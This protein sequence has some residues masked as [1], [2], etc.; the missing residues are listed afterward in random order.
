M[1]PSK[2]CFLMSLCIFKWTLCLKLCFFVCMFTSGKL[3]LFFNIFLDLVPAVVVFCFC[4]FFLTSC[5]STTR[6]R[7]PHTHTS[8]KLFFV[9]YTHT[10]CCDGSSLYFLFF[11]VFLYE[12]AMTRATSTKI[13]GGD[14]DKLYLFCI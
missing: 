9:V 3:R 2:L 14:N 5:L 4:F 11:T 6:T 8:Q 13:C 12:T 1:K 10:G 7:A